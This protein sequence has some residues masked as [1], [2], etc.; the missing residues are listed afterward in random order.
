MEERKTILARI[1]ISKE[2]SVGEE[3]KKGFLAKAEEL[4]DMADKIDTNGVLYVLMNSG[5]EKFS[6]DSKIIRDI[7]DLPYLY[8]HHKL[9]RKPELASEFTELYQHIKE[10]N[11]IV[12]KRRK[13]D[14]KSRKER[15]KR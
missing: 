14:A 6:P 8:S 15:S 10:I 5:R 9:Q 11:K 7:M 3:V 13:I 12:G 4:R 2:V 1:S